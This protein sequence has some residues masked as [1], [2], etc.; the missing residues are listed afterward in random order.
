MGSRVSHGTGTRLNCTATLDPLI[1]YR[2]LTSE[3]ELAMTRGKPGTTPAGFEPGP[4][5]R[6]LMTMRGGYGW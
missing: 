4:G 5:C 1:R 6:R 3:R 2:Y